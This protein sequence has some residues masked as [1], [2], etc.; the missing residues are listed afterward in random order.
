MSVKL[1]II[2][3]N[4]RAEFAFFMILLVMFSKFMFLKSCILS[5]RLTTLVAQVRLTSAVNA[6]HVI[7]Q[8]LRR[9]ENFRT[10]LVETRM[11]VSFNLIMC[12][13]EANF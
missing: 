5:E 3:K 1:I 7:F 10:T 9:A 2:I 12:L 11:M 13:F 4:S 6:R 8:L